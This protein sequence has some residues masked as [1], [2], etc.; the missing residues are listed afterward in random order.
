[1]KCVPEDIEVVFIYAEVGLQ[2]GIVSDRE[3]E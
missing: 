3:S 1:M 2:L